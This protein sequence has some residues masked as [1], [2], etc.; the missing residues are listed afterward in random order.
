MRVK[1]PVAI[2]TGAG[3]GIGRAIALELARA[4]YSLCL[5]ARTVDELIETRRLSGLDPARSLIVLADLAQEE[6][7][8]NLFHAALQHF[9]RIDVLVNNA[10]WGPPR[11]PMTRLR[12]DDEAR[13]LAVNLRAPITLSRKA[14]ALMQKQGGGVIINIAS[15]AARATPA[16]EA[17]YAASKAGLV[18]FTHACFKELRGR[19]LKV[20]VI[21]PGLVDTGL[22][23]P[24]RRLNRSAMIPAAAIA[25]AVMY[26]IRAPAAVCPLE[27][28]LEPSADPLE[29]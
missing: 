9:Q 25:E 18:A 2:V 27:V 21:L 26:V 13:I 12:A 3:R 23:P 15:A 8:E 28:V 14:A 20:S 29:R 17:V 16:G 7:A 22:I 1:E 6:A 10:G 19:G 24:N 4:G 11:S 5:S